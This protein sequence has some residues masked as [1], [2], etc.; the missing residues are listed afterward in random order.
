MKEI[1]RLIMNIVLGI[2]TGFACI[3]VLLAGIGMVDYLTIEVTGSKIVECY[4][5]EDNIIQGLKCTEETSC[6][7]LGLS[8]FD[9]C[10]E[11]KG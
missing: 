9:K 1:E 6:S 4:D 3:M 5:N 8:A 7:W 10:S 2:I 11:V